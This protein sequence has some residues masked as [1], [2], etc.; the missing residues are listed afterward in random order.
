MDQRSSRALCTRS[1][2]T[3]RDGAPLESNSAIKYVAQCSREPLLSYD[4]AHSR[5]INGRDVVEGADVRL[6]AK[7]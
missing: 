7:K 1:Q 5:E 3:K 6:S 2:E 4:R